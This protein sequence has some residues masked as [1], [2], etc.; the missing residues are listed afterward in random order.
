M[1]TYEKKPGIPVY[2]KI[3]E[4]HEIL[5]LFSVLFAECILNFK[6]SCWFV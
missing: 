1:Y 5:E 2:Q 6:S 3:R 4:I